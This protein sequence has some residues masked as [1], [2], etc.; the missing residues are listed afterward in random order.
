MVSVKVT[1]IPLARVKT[2]LKNANPEWK[3]GAADAQLLLVLAGQQ[4][5]RHVSSQVYQ[6]VQGTG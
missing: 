6:H 5:C 4:F 2:M 1:E 3:G